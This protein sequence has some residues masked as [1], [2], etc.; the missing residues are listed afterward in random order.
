MRPSVIGGTT[1][2]AAR[3]AAMPLPRVPDD[4]LQISVI[5]PPTKLV[6]GSVGCCIEYRRISRTAWR[7][8][9]CH[10]TADDPAHG[11]D[12]RFHRVGRSRA[13]IEGARWRAA[14]EGF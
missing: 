1:P 6:A 5:R 14:L 11:V 3:V 4:N 10:R 2:I 12:H 13:D 8:L 9:P 7:R